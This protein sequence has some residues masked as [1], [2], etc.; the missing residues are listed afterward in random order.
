MKISTHFLLPFPRK[1]LFVRKSPKLFYFNFIFILF[2]FPVILEEQEVV[3]A[4]KA[5][6][7]MPGHL[8]LKAR[9]QLPP[10]LLWLRS[11]KNGVKN[12]GQSE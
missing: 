9:P 5:D 4:T 11:P 1:Q 2:Y 12:P 6:G 7:R 3:N 10:Q 8:L